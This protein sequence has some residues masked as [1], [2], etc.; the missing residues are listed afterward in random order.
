MKRDAG[1]LVFRVSMG[2]MMILHG[3]MKIAGGSEFIQRLGGLPPLVPDNDALRLILGLIA[4]SFEIVGGLGVVTGY[5]FRTACTMII[6]VMIPA[7]LYHLGGVSDFE[8]FV[9]NT[10]PLELAFVF[11]AFILIGPG[12]HK[13]G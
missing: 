9:R 7:F 2:T 6:L 8:S 13:L 10:W 1:I 12:K 3:I 4:V 11:T 5:R